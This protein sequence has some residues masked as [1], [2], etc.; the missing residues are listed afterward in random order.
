MEKSQRLK[1]RKILLTI[2]SNLFLALSRLK[3]VRGPG[4][5]IP[6]PLDKFTAIFIFFRVCN[7]YCV[8]GLGVLFSIPSAIPSIMFFI[9]SGF[10]M[11]SI[12]CFMPFFSSSGMSTYQTPLI[13]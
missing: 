6:K 13:L 9:F 1:Q 10:F 8:G 3:I 12:I 11:N 7:P 2:P 5:Q 4:K